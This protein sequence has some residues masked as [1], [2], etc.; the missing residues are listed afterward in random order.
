MPGGCH[1]DGAIYKARDE[2][3][4]GRVSDWTQ[5]DSKL[6][7]VHKYVQNRTPYCAVTKSAPGQGLLLPP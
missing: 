4:D 7:T 6:V 5:C 1:L 2:T 3:D